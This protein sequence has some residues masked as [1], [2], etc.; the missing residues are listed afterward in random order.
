MT[1]PAQGAGRPLQF[2]DQPDRL[3]ARGDRPPPAPQCGVRGERFVLRSIKYGINGAV[4]AGLIAVPA[5][6]S[7]VDKSVP[8]VVDGQARTVQT[9]A[10]DVGQVLSAHGYR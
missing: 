4:I 8:L 1:P 2:R 9:T 3:T 7:T 10:G 5:A 6:W